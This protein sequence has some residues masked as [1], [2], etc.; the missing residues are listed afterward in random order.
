[1]AAQRQRAGFGTQNDRTALDGRSRRRQ[2]AVLLDPTRDDR[3]I[4]LRRGNRSVVDHG[5]RHDRGLIRAV[6]GEHVRAVTC[7]TDS[8]A[9]EVGIGRLERRIGAAEENRLP[10]GRADGTVVLYRRRKQQRLAGRV[11]L[12]A[13]LDPYRVGGTGVALVDEGW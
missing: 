13:R 2:D 3:D 10:R 11:D 1:G 12:C 4:T 9:A 5:P 8:E 7:G 6:R